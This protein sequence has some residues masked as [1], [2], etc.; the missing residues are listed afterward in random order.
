MIVPSF[1]HP[2]HCQ[3]VCSSF[4][5]SLGATSRSSDWGCRQPWLTR[6]G[7]RSK[8]FP[9]PKLDQ[10]GCLMPEFSLSSLPQ[11]IFFIIVD[12]QCCVNFCYMQS[13]PVIHIYTFFFSHYPPSCSITS[14]QISFPVL[15]CR[16]S[17][18][19]PSKCNSLHL[20]TPN[21]ISPRSFLSP[22]SLFSMSV[23]LFLF[24][25]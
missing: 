4:P 1:G 15:Y 5:G 14:D 2:C 13:D 16:I 21:S 8:S 24:C 7:M 3:S 19:I 25:R 20:L 17:L 10:H 18:L 12:L 23:S 9:H 6:V 11:Y 22:T